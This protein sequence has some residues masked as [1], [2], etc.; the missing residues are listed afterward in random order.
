MGKRFRWGIGLVIVLGLLGYFVVS[1]A[2]ALQGLQK[3]IL[4]KDSRALERYLDFPKVREALTQDITAKIRHELDA[5]DDNA[6]GRI[7]TMLSGGIVN[8][9]VNRI[10]TPEG[11]A[12][13]GSD[14][15]KNASQGK[16]Q[17]VEAVKDWRVR[18]ELPLTLRI[19]NSKNPSSGLRMQ[20][21]GFSWKVVRIDLG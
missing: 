9:L 15:L 12:N 1:P 14:S 18:L 21:Q 17:G 3:A 2:L 19:Y 6:L 16:K 5:N 8:Q 10:V 11:L 4:A 7:G 20:P 13:I